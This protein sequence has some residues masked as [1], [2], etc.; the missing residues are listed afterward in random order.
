MA[1]PARP[2]PPSLLHQFGGGESDMFDG[3]HLALSIG[4]GDQSA[5][6]EM[7][8]SH[9]RVMVSNLAVIQS[10]KPAWAV[11]RVA[12]FTSL[13]VCSSCSL[14]CF[15]FSKFKRRSHCRCHYRHV[16]AVKDSP[17]HHRAIPA[18][19]NLRSLRLEPTTTDTRERFG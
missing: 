10:S 16:P 14:C 4:S 1:R 11:A 13:F 15:L 18:S 12:T 2:A 3:N 17:S 5:A 8:G 9:C 7:F 6:S 19:P